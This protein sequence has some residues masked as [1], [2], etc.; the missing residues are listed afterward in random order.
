VFVEDTHYYLQIVSMGEADKSGKVVAPD[1]GW[2]WV[3][4]I[5]VMVVNVSS[6]IHERN[7]QILDTL[8]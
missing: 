3:V 7:P 1:G 5:G 8:S 6:C 2:G 4:V